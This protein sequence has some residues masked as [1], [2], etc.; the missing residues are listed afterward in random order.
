MSLFLEDTI[1]LSNREIPVKVGYL[2]HATL[3]FY[4]ENPRIYSIV[5]KDSDVEPSQEE[6]FDKLSKTEHVRENL[7]PSIRRNGGLREP[8]LVRNNVVLEGNSR[9]AAYRI[10]SQTDPEAWS[11]IRV[12]IL[13]DS[14]TDS[15][16]FS[17][18]G[19]MHIVGK[20]DWLKYEQ[21]GYLYR[22]FKIHGVDEKQLHQ[23]IG[24]PL[25]TIRLLI[26]VHD[27]MIEVGD[28]TPERWSYYYELLKGRKFNQT[29][30]LY[31]EFDK[32]I[33]EMIQSEEIE[34]AVDLR[35]GLAKIVKVGGNTLKKFMNGNLSFHDAVQDA[36]LRGA[37]NYYSK[38]FSEFRKWL[39]DDQ[40]DAEVMS[41]PVEEKKALTYELSKIESRI[42]QL[43]KKVNRHA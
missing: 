32:K 3:L 41:I 4:A 27:F 39:A 34:R 17:L 5:W 7:V 37:G 30:E 10:L 15:D 16:V 23:E 1:T 31:P 21:A 26:R 19:E 42:K 43:A 35:D 36:H 40:I 11:Q 9:L 14:I 28:R 29:R 2:P 12:R 6:I 38:K 13:P 33:A 18:L 24:L 22:R 20:K 8:V 25:A